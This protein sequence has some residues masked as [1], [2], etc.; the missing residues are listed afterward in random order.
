M[1]IFKPVLQ[2]QAVNGDQAHDSKELEQPSQALSEDSHCCG[3]SQYLLLAQHAWGH[4]DHGQTQGP[5]HSNN[6][7]PLGS[8]GGGGKVRKKNVMC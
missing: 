4:R 5:L 6:T 7:R 2:L 1:V 8:G 3:G